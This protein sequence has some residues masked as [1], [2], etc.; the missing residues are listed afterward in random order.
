MGLGGIVSGIAGIAGGLGKS[1]DRAAYTEQQ[2][3]FRT[4]PKEM[5]DWMMGDV[6]DRVKSLLNQPSPFSKLT[7]GINSEDT[8]PIFGSPARTSYIQ[9]LIQQQLGA[10]TPTSSNLVEMRGGV[11]TYNKALY[12]SNP[13]YKAAWDSTAARHKDK[14]GVDYRQDSSADNIKA[15]LMNILKM[16]G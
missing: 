6:Y 14:Y 15:A 9:N 3:G 13:D 5:Q 11:P 7:R 2:S 1:K 8:D 12:E 16:K 4:L 10:R